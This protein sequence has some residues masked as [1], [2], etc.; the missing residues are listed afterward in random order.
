MVIESKRLILRAWRQNDAAALYS[1]ACNPAV[2]DA[3][4]WPAHSSPN[5][6]AEVIR[7]YFAEPETYAV[8]PKTTGEPA[9]CIGLVPRAA[10]HYAKIGSN[11]REIGYWIGQELWGQGMIP[12]ALNALIDYW[13]LNYGFSE[14]WIITYSENAKSQ[15]VAD[16]CG[17]RFVEDFT[18]DDSRPSKAFVL[19]LKQSA[20]AER[21]K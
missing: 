9:G 8:V 19:Q 2:A 6:S 21:D 15:R 14:L 16:K 1:H 18:D 11:A 20:D 3:A 17:F 12:E 5:M 7:T 13:R 10:E 4:G